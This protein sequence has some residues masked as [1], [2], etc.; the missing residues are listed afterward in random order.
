MS[1][2]QPNKYDKYILT[3]LPNRNEDGTF[4]DSFDFCNYRF[5]HGENGYEEHF[6]CFTAQH[7]VGG[8]TG[9]HHIQAFIQTKRRLRY[10]QISELLCVR[11]DQVHYREVIRTPE[12]AWDYCSEQKND[13]RHPGVHRDGEEEEERGTRCGCPSWSFGQRPVSKRGGQRGGAG[14]KPVDWLFL[15]DLAKSGV[16]ERE[17]LN[18]D[19]TAGIILAHHNAFRWCK[20]VLTAPSN[21]PSEWSKR[22]VIVYYGKAGVGK[23]QRV[24]EECARFGLSLWVAPAGPVGVWYD[25]YDNHAAALFDD[26]VGGMPFRDLL[27]LLEGNEVRVQVKGS[28]VTFKPSVVFFTSDRHWREWMFPKGPDRGLGPMSADEEA[29]LGRRVTSCEEVFKARTVSEA[30]GM[31]PSRVGG[32]NTGAPDVALS[33]PTHEFFTSEGEMEEIMAELFPNFY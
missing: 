17:L 3:V 33:P 32:D 7:E 24:R 28:H 31:N 25:G 6:V 14:R 16:S 23:S 8:H 20:S 18:R 26:F 22:S 5:P 11:P 10:S 9:R 21:T 13:G 4:D 2:R 29:Q 15:R 1:V 19:D 12:K 27:N 30:L